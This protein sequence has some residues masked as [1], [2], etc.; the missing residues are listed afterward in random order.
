MGNLI[1]TSSRIQSYKDDEK[2]LDVPKVHDAN[3]KDE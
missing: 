1:L 3:D 2:T